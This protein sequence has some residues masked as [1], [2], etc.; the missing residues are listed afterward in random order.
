MGRAPIVVSPYD[1][2]LYGHWWY[3]GPMF[4]DYLVR[5]AAFDQRVFRLATPGDYLREN[6][7]QQLATPP[8]CSWGAGGYAGVWLDQATGLAPNFTLLF[9]ISGIAI[10]FKGFIQEV[11][12]ERRAKS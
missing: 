1:A 3:E 5:K 12:I 8:L 4:I 6:P 2:E 7:E 10:G 11:I 9:L